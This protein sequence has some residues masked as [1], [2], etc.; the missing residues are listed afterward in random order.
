M[1]LETPKHEEFKNIINM[2][3][4]INN[5]C[6]FELFDDKI[7]ALI[8][9]PQNTVFVLFEIKSKFFTKYDKELS[10]KITIDIS[11]LHK[12]L[13]NKKD[14]I[15]LSTNSDDSKII[16]KSKN[17]ETGMPL[18][19][20]IEQ[21]RTFEQVKK[22]TDE[23]IPESIIKL[24]PLQLLE[25]IGE[26]TFLTSDK[27]ITLKINESQIKISNITD[28]NKNSVVKIPMLDNIKIECKEETKVKINYDLLSEILTPLTKL[29]EILI[30]SIKK[31][32]P[33]IIKAIAPNM[34]I[35][36]II[37]PFVDND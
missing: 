21:P 28:E 32:S 30:I 29:S 12:V 23:I 5:D 14:K 18:I 16:L 24:S 8:S 17:T 35:T 31:Q 4:S 27:T 11:D 33:L 13:Y 36:I 22:S 9:N 1:I 37:A 10:E 20:T 19:E 2:L 25:F 34:D 3:N 26:I 7:R 6:L 15:N